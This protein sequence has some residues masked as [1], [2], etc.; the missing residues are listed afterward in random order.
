M[1]YV[2]SSIDIG[3]R[4]RRH[5][6][7]ACVLNSKN[8]F[9][10]AIRDFGPEE[11]D[12]EVLE[13]CDRSEMRSREDFWIAFIG[14]NNSDDLNTNLSSSWKGLS[15]L[16]RERISKA[17][18]GRLNSEEHKKNCSKALKAYWAIHPFPKLS[19]ERRAKL[20]E[21]SRLRKGKFTPETLEK[22]RI[23]STGKR[24]TEESKRKLSEKL[25]GRV[26]SP[27]SRAKMSAAQKGRVHSP[28]W[29]LNHSKFMT[30]RKLTEEHKLKTGATMKRIWAERRAS[31]QFSTLGELGGR[32][33]VSDLTTA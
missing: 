20:I 26:M 30:G 4:R 1:C 9:H 10:T 11:F 24:H 5:I 8:R 28:E 14:S 22:M 32:N 19:E 23:A 29:C 16:T 27:E 3:G 18:K 25:K 33:A 15:D 21:L 13:R 12:F 31:K 7:L 6:R 2:G 17:N